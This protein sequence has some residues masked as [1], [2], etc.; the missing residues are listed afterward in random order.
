MILLKTLSLFVVTA[1]AEPH[2][3]PFHKGPLDGHDALA[4]L[5]ETRLSARARLAGLFLAGDVVEWLDQVNVAAGQGSVAATCAQLAAR[6][7]QRN[8]RSAR[9]VTASP[10]RRTPVTHLC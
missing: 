10:P 7:R 9:G 6:A 4:P 2:I 1:L 8:S 3:L 5:D